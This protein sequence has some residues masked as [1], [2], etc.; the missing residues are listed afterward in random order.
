ML[1]TAFIYIIVSESE[2]MTIWK[3]FVKSYNKAYAFMWLLNM[4]LKEKYKK[5]PPRYRR[6]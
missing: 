6:S 4:A 1:Y 2:K 5:A 3:K